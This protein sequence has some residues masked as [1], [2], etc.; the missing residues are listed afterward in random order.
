MKK[1]EPVSEEELAELLPDD[2]GTFV[3]FLDS[4]YGGKL[5]ACIGRASLDVL[6]ESELARA[7]QETLIAVWTTVQKPG[8]EPNRP[9]RIVFAI[10]KNKALD[11]LRR[12]F[13]RTKRRVLNESDVTNLVISDLEGTNLGIDWK[14][15]GEEE[16]RR[17]HEV[18]PEII[19]TLSPRQRAAAAAFYACFEQVRPND[20]YRPIVEAMSAI[21]GQ[22]ETVA[23]AKSALTAAF[24]KIR[25]ELVR[26]GI[27]FVERSER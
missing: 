4:D 1:A 27:S 22:A 11:A 23:A 13:G 20:K 25:A 18:L 8:F 24:A 10:A 26:R 6:D 21:T 16:K 15:A 3:T 17:L 14:Y 12:K 2:P 5:M 19:E 9:L 7:Y